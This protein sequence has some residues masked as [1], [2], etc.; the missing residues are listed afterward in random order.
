MHDLVARNANIVATQTF[1]PRINASSSKHPDD[2][3]GAEVRVGAKIDGYTTFVFSTWKLIDASTSS[4]A[5]FVLYGQITGTSEH[6]YHWNNGGTITDAFTYQLHPTAWVDPPAE[7]TEEEECLANGG[8]WWPEYTPPCQ[9][10]NCPVLINIGGE[11][12][13]LTRAE[14]GVTFDI[15]ATGIPQRIGW[16]RSGSAVG[17][18]ALDRN[19][20]GRIDDGSELFG[21][22]TVQSDGTNALNGFEALID[23]DGGPWGSDGRLDS[24]DA[25]F[26]HLQLWQ[27]RNHN[28]LSEETELSRLA[29]LGIE[30]II[31]GYHRA[32]RRDRAG[33]TFIFGGRVLIRDGQ[34]G[35]I[36]RSVYDVNFAETR[37]QTTRIL[38][39]RPSR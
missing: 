20:N 8:Q 36:E 11:D 26:S 21:T 35:T 32:G 38:G 17:L 15:E 19:G 37:L 10:V 34:G 25:V 13:P 6:L 22:A 27:D 2:P 33:N 12:Y 28:G 5:P 18:L 1:A 16:T 31:L 39:R 14:A 30:A 29:D 23:L 9:Y 3:C 24:T 4:Q 7:P